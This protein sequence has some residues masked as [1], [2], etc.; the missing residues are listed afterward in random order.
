MRLRL[1][2][3]TCSL[4]EPPEGHRENSIDVKEIQDMYQFMAI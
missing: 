3:D 4:C 1:G 2:V